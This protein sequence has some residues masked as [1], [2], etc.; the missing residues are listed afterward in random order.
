L[1]KGPG[2]R[3]TGRNNSDQYFPPTKERVTVAGRKGP[4]KQN[5]EIQV[6]YE[7]TM[8]PRKERGR[9][10]EGKARTYIPGD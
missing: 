9:K 2:R 5:E 1:G 7:A 10:S 3:N 4:R 6:I 8:I